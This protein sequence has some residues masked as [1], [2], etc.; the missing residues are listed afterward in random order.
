MGGGLDK[1]QVRDIDYLLWGAGQETSQGY[2][3][4]PVGGWTRDK[5]GI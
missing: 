4:S 1:R 5:S 2:R 3:L